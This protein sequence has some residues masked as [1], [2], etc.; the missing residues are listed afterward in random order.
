MNTGCRIGV[1]GG[2]EE[3]TGGVSGGVP[4]VL[5]YI[6]E[7]TAAAS[8]PDTLTAGAPPVISALTAAAGTRSCIP[9]PAPSITWI[10]TR[11]LKWCGYS[12]SHP[13]G[14]SRKCGGDDCT[15]VAVAA[16]AT[17]EAETTVAAGPLLTPV[18]GI[19]GRRLALTPADTR[20]PLQGLC[21]CC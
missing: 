16:A 4:G 19:G 17:I 6:M 7:P 9:G 13:G 2:G 8:V 10:G 12:C 20:P 5:G 11:C 15:S 3:L 14:V 21:C 18:M 1:V